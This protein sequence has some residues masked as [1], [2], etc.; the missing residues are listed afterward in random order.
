MIDLKTAF[1]HFYRY[2]ERKNFGL[3][4]REWHRKT[5]LYFRKVASGIPF[6]EFATC[7]ETQ[8][9]NSLSDFNH[10]NIEKLVDF[11]NDRQLEPETIR[12]TIRSLRAFYKWMVRQQNIEVYGE[13][14]E[15]NEYIKSGLPLNTFTNLRDLLP[16]LGPKK[17]KSLPSEEIAKLKKLVMSYRKS[18]DEFIVLRNRAIILSYIYTGMRFNELRGIK[19][20]DLKLEEGKILLFRHKTKSYTDMDLN[21]QFYYPLSRY[22]RHLEEKGIFTG[23]LFWAKTPSKPISEK[24]IRRIK[25]QFDK[26]IEGKLNV[27]KWS[28]NNLRHSFATHLLDA[29]VNLTVVSNYMG[30]SSYKTTLN[31]LHREPGMGKDTI[32]RLP[33]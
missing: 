4:S 18:E 29:K 5:L 1:Q 20:E 28:F 33:Y 3:S 13:K 14:N 32:N 16:A 6:E 24:Q 21:D 12:T 19:R 2:H 17:K 15:P 27:E 9:I 25:A 31:Y 7:N 11:Q 8:L 26:S 22:L 30:H 23:Y 10:K